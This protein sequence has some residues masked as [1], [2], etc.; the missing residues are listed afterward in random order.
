M[1]MKKY[2][3]ALMFSAA[4]H[5]AFAAPVQDV[6]RIVAVV[7]KDV[8]TEL[9][10]R[11]RVDEAV[12]SLK[13]QHVA[14]PSTDVLRKQVLDQMIIETAQQQFASDNHVTVSDAD[15]NEAVGRV[16]ANNKVDRDGLKKLL[17]KQGIDYNIFLVDLKRELLLAKLKDSVLASRVTVT[18]SEVDQ[19]M[20][21]SLLANS[22]EYHL[23]NILIEVPERADGATIDAKLKR[24]HDALAELNAGKPFGSVAASYSGAA[25]ALRGGDLGWRPAASLPPEFTAMLETLKPGQH[26]DVIRTQQG[27]FIFQLVDKRNQQ[28]QQMAEQYHVSHIL[29]RTNEAVT[30]SDAR[31][32]ILQIRDRILRGASFADM[33]KLYSED[34]SNS[35]GG[36]LGWLSQGDTVP[37]FE[38][39]MMSL[40]LNTV[41]EPV[42]T[43]FGWHLI[44]VEGTRNQD[45]SSD[46]TRSLIRQQIR[47][48]KIEEAYLDWLSQLR[49]S[50]FIDN[51]LN[52]Q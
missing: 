22:T 20:K 11:A 6:D 46:R 31:T 33:A 50:T 2:L 23:A 30:D 47:Q 16:A 45:V 51:R 18:D 26:T 7:N 4:M 40:P 25:N 17:A 36:D 9:D 48:R 3:Y 34:G 49:D 21:N 37:E 19:A 24:A 14:P 29:I 32:K 39:V 27:F 42:R 44:M 43:Q 35:R 12:L 8:I 41:S 13:E 52:D 15:V 38:H 10:L 5:A 28:T 1:T